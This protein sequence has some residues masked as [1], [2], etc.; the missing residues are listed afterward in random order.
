MKRLLSIVFFFFMLHIGGLYAQ[1]RPITVILMR[2]AEKD[3]DGTKDPSLSAVGQEFAQKLT[4]VFAETKVDAVYSTPFKR[5]IQTVTPLAN[6]SRVTVNTYDASKSQELM[7]KIEKSKEKTVVI[8]GHSNT[9]QLVF[10]TLIK[11]K[12]LQPLG[13]DEYRKVFI[14]TY[15]PKEPGKSTWLKLDLN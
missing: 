1:E 10:N 8:A 7:D 9:I 14:I 3:N 6:Q 13:D 12:Q 15:D 4:H 2:H 11:S 5:T